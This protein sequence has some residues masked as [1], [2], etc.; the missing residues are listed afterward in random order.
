MAVQNSERLKYAVRQETANSPLNNQLEEDNRDLM[1]LEGYFDNFS[2]AAV[3]DK[4]G[5]QRGLL[6]TTTLSTSN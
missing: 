2:A 6:N 5:L 4:G 3:N 1:T